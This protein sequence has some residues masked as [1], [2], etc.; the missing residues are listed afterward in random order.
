M[1]R[2]SQRKRKPSASNGW[3]AIPGEKLTVDIGHGV[4]ND[5]T[6]TGDVSRWISPH[7]NDDDD[8]GENDSAASRDLFDPDSKLDRVEEGGAA[9]FGMLYS[10]EVISGA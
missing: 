4:S 7:Y 3:S 8:D 9:E 5:A 6:S 10:L 1:T 2:K